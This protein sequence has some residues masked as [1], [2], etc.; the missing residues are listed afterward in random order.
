MRR[1]EPTQFE[2]SPYAGR[3]EALIGGLTRLSDR[4]CD[5][6]RLMADG[7]S[8]RAIAEVLVVGER[9]VESHV[10]SIF[11][12]LELP[13]TRDEHRRVRAVVAFLLFGT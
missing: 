13:P 4:E 2:W 8:N 6:L 12:K 7:C 11:Q 1:T 3:R 10:A 5:V 9:T